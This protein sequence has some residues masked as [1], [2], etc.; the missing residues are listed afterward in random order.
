MERRAQGEGT[1]YQRA[2][3]RW[4]G[5]IRLEFPSGHKRIGVYGKTR[6]EVS[7]KIRDV[8]RKHHA[9]ELT[10]TKPQAL[11][12]Y[13]EEWWPT[14][15]NIKTSSYLTRKMN[16]ERI[17]RAIGNIPLNEVSV[18]HIKTLDNHLREKGGKHGQ[19]LSASSRKQA[20]AILRT[21]LGD[22]HA[23]DR[24]SQ[25]PFSKWRRADAPR[26]Q[27]REMRVLSMDEQSK[28]LS[29]NDKWTPAW[30]IQLFTGNRIGETLALTWD[31]L[32]LPEDEKENGLLRINK[33]IHRRIINSAVN[34]DWLGYG[35]KYYLDKPKTKTSTREV[36][37]PPFFVQVF[38][39]V[40]KS[41]E[42]EAERIKEKGEK[43]E[44]WSNPKGFV[45][46]RF[47]G[48]P[49]T[50]DMAWDSMQTSAKKA[51]LISDSKPLPVHSLRHTMITDRIMD[52]TPLEKISKAV[53]HSSVAFT[54]DVYG[55]LT[56]EMSTEV[57][58][59]SS[60]SVE[61]AVRFGELQKLAKS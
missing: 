51:G 45:F 13:L 53:G 5:R 12:D 50:P 9:K 10:I 1:I 47:L 44:A 19:G 48:E 34:P 59:A 42:A 56:K 33:A 32:D 57:A 16:C 3:G 54:A 31:D 8:M 61:R 21:A 27:H 46:T 58:E 7:R 37:L 41:Q 11:R 52:G 39:D 38:K 55:H 28:L 43:D 35:A 22:A 30:K 40:R 15:N 2:D 60:R 26:S 18:R 23:E 29:L 6:G 36:V 24:I 49:I 4:H 20:L 17:S 25:N 14:G